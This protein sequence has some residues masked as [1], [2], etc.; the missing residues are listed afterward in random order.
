MFAEVSC[1]GADDSPA[2]M[3]DCVR[4]AGVMPVPVRECRVPCRDECSFTSWSRFTQCQGCGSW[5]TRTRSLIGKLTAFWLSQCFL[6]AHTPSKLPFR[7]NSQVA[8]RSAGDANRRSC[9]LSW[10]KKLVLVLNFTPSLRVPGLLVCSHQQRI[11][12]AILSSKEFPTKAKR[13]SRTGELRGRTAS[14]GTG[15]ATELSPVSITW[16]NWWIQISVAALVMCSS[17]YTVY[18][19]FL[20]VYIN[21]FL[22]SKCHAC[23]YRLWRRSV[24]C[25]LFYGLQAEWV[26]KLVRLQRLLW[27]GC[28]SSLSVA[29]REAF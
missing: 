21:V 14:V 13:Q 10:R 17:I 19:V 2:D 24:S 22:S 27:W 12:L 15:S 25:G 9:F 23:G 8:V 26:V 4:W 29:T 16:E 6:K 5:R 18:V 28:K 11:L 20:N 1:V 3:T 7:P